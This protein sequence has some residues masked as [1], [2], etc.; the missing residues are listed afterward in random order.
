MYGDTVFY[1]NGLHTYNA[2]TYY[3]EINF[4]EMIAPQV[5]NSLV[6]IGIQQTSYIQQSKIFLKTDRFLKCWKGENKRYFP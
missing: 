6:F 1:E 3:S 5:R 4:L 2:V